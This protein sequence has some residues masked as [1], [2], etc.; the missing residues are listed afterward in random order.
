MLVANIAYWTA[1]G[2]R[3][4]IAPQA[5]IVSGGGCSAQ[6]VDQALGAVLDRRTGANGANLLEG[7]LRA[8]VVRPDEEDHALDES[9]RVPQHQLLQLSIARTAPVRSG[10]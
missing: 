8:Q 3:C 7:A 5:M 1:P 10:Q 6:F 9:E 4:S 2:A